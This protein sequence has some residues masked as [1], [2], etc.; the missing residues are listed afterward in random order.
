LGRFGLVRPSFIPPK[1][2]RELRL[3]SRYR[4]KLSQ[5]QA[6]EKHRLHKVPDDAGI[7]LGAVVADIG[8][9]SARAMID[10]FLVGKPIE[11]LADLAKGVMRHKR[12]VLECSLEGEL[13]TRHRFVLEH[14][15]AHQRYLAAA[16]CPGNHESAGKRKTGKTRQGNH[17]IRF[18]P[19]EAANAARRTKSS[20]HE[21]YQ[22]L[23]VR[24]GHKKAIIAVAHP[25][26]RT[27]Y[28][29]FTR[30]HAYRDSGFDYQA[31][32]VK[33]NAPRWIKA[34]K[35]FGYWPKSDTSAHP[36]WVPAR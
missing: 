33:K 35:Q 18:L 12:E 5:M 26:L 8:G 27:I 19:C 23:V 28:V 24:R 31:A 30:R 15:Q 2:L 7:K 36:A 9:V 22:S 32:L 29:L 1:D 34:L 20:L 13:T 6:S 14:L 16:L 17:A 21:K 3:V 10:G 11:Q 4:Q 25:I